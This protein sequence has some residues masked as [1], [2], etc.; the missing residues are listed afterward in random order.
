MSPVHEPLTSQRQDPRISAVALPSAEFGKL[1][2]P[3]LIVISFPK[4]VKMEFVSLRIVS[5]IRL[6]ILL[7]MDFILNNK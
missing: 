4:A 7:P 3:F 1:A 6:L 2:S 5:M